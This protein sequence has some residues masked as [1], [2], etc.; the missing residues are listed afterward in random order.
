MTFLRLAILELKRFRSP[1]LRR[2][3]LVALI[4]I[5]L[6]YGG[7]YLWSNWDPYGRLDQIPVAVV[8]DD[9]PVES[10]GRRIAAGEQFTQQLRSDQIFDWQFVDQS[11]AQDGLEQGQYYFTIH[12]PHDFSAKLATA[13]ED[14]PERAELSITKNDANGYIAGIMADTA[15]GELQN[16]I[17]AATHAA[18]AKALYGEVETVREKL[19]FASQASHDLVTGTDLSAEGTAGLSEG[20]EQ[21]H[22]G[23]DDVSSGTDMISTAVGQMEDQISTV[24]NL[25]AEEMPGIVNTMVETS[26]AAETG[27][28][29][30][31][32]G[33]G[34]IDTRAQNGLTDLESLGERHDL[35]EDPAYQSAVANA[36]EL[37]ETTERIDGRAQ[38]ALDDVTEAQQRAT[39]LQDEMGTL[40][41]RVRDLSTPI[42]TLHSG[43]EGVSTG[44]DGLTNGIDTL[45]SSSEVLNSGADELSEGAHRLEDMVN[46]TL[47]K[48]PPTDPEQVAQAAE[49]L[50]SPTTVHTDNLNSADVYGRGLAPF[51]FSIALWVF[52]LFAYLLLKPFN[53]RALA[54]RS[55]A[56]TIALGGWLPAAGL[57][58]LGGLVLFTVVDL[59]LGLNP[60][61]LFGT[62][63]IIALAAVTFVAIDQFL[64]AALGAVGDLISLVLLILQITASGGLYPMETTPALFQTINPVLPMTYLVDGLRVT[65]S[66][67]LTEHLVRDVLVLAGFLVVFLVLTMFTVRRQRTWTV[68]RLHP[69]IEI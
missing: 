13:T 52:G 54:G 66:G 53:E 49:V 1:L 36:R 10:E 21:L 25:A 7:L 65:I 46:D 42:Q 50:G 38:H 28:S 33:T 43:T 63:G 6:L 27:L 60:V 32:E 44:T 4:L 35:T 57:A 11:E 9:H 18:Y 17:N 34:E 64:R 31:K 51:F 48:L 8:N 23:A 41:Q 15:K 59:G 62:L 20:M 16:Q 58:V 22:D 67:G 37:T 40:Q 12:V 2:L 69:Q 19:R 24:T 30:V 26:G 14:N 29:T 39:T 61:Q 68:G 56:F 45:A 5:P 47:A 3:T 55:H